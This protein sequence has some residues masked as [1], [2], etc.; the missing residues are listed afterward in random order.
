MRTTR[1]SEFNHELHK[2][3]ITTSNMN[4]SHNQTTEA[5]NT[6][7]SLKKTRP[8][9]VLPSSYLRDIF[10]LPLS[11]LR[12]TIILEGASEVELRY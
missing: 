5:N 6:A 8:T 12:P 1:I 11:D 7:I 9:F 2:Q 10:V 4:N 3:D